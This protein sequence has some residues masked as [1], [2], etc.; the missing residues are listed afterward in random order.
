MLFTD[1]L[2][3]EKQ[4]ISEMELT[5]ESQSYITA[6][7]DTTAVTLT[8][9]VYAVCQD[10][11]IRDRLV[12]ELRDVPEQLSHTDVKNLPYLNQVIDEA[13]RLYG[14]APG[15]L[16][17][18]VPGGGATLAG[19]RLPGGTTVSTQAY[20]LHRDPVAFPDPERY[21]FSLLVCS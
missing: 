10:R 6:G 14:A 7:T 5:F 4:E 13:L 11:T 19:H 8:Y 9:L 18:V 20:S 2:R 1:L 12:M 16:P 21:S 3:A 17:R 15:A